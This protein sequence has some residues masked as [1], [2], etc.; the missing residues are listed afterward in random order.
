MPSRRH[1]S[2]ARRRR[3]SVSLGLPRRSLLLLAIVASMIAGGAALAGEEPPSESLDSSSTATQGLSGDSGVSVQTVCTNCNNADLSVGGLG[4][5]HVEVVCDD[6]PVATG[7]GQIY[8]LTVMPGTVIDKIT[9]KRG[10]GQPELEASAVGGGILIRRREPREGLQL[11]TSADGGSFGWGGARVD[12][13]GRKDWFG[14]AFVGTY[15]RSDR[16]D[17][18]SDGNPDLPSYDRSTWDGRVVMRPGRRHTIR[19]GTQGYEESQKDGAAAVR[20]ILQPGAGLVLAQRSDGTY[21]YNLED[22]DLLRHAYDLGYEI[23]LG[24]GSKLG[25]NGAWSRRNEDINEQGVIPFPS[26]VDRF[27]PTYQIEDTHTWAGATWSRPVGSRF[28][29]R[30][31]AAWSGM[32][33]AVV[34]TVTN[35]RDQRPTD[36]AYEENPTETGIW[37]ETEASLG[38]D[39][40][41]LVGV[42]YASVSYSDNETRP[43]WSE[44]PLPGGVRYLPRTALTWKPVRDWM[45]RFS[46]G[47]GFRTPAPTYQEVC[48]GRRYRNNRYMS[49]EDSISYGIEA[50]FQPKPSIKVAATVFQSDFDEYVLRLVG[51]SNAFR[52]V[53]QNTN[54]PKARLR[55]AGIEGRWEASAWLTVRGAMSWLTPENRTEGGA[56]PLVADTGVPSAATFYSSKLPYL[57]SSAGSLALDF[58]PGPGGATASVSLAYTGSMRIQWFTESTVVIPYTYSEPLPPAVINQS[59]ST[60]TQP[61]FVGTPSFW[62]INFRADFPFRNGIAVY[63]GADNITD[64]VMGDLG[65]PAFDYKWGPLRGRYFYGGLGYRFGS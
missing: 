39:V 22:V 37:A 7:L 16:I 13:S 42:R 23:D 48:C 30:A 50:T 52:P 4:N 2:P 55:S 59:I 63:A 6:I 53:Y 17:S 41:L 56:I 29:V 61:S 51:L 8:L 5:E 25:V 49:M 12:L 1:A 20:T 58:R 46:A 27:F 28:I 65:D 47:A 43:L 62:T 35:I 15:G 24:G 14:G 31:G 33:A 34:D 10:A 3:V 45:L 19:L 54:V 57:A 40:S 36:F 11:N 32:E 44:L 9:V 18:N 21:I 64:Y 38:P 26:V 60:Q